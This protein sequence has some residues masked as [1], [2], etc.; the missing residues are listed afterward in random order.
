MQDDGDRFN[1]TVSIIICYIPQTRG[2]SAYAYYGRL[3]GGSSGIMSNQSDSLHFGKMVAME[4]LVKAPRNHGLVEPSFTHRQDLSHDRDIQD[5]RPKNRMIHF[6]RPEN[7]F[8]RVTV[9]T[10]EQQGTLGYTRYYTG[11]WSPEEHGTTPWGIT[12]SRAP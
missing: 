3:M 6:V 4:V 9:A 8:Y 2:R 5:V 7:R 12:Q 1:T 10:E 11:N